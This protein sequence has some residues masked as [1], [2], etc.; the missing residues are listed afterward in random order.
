MNEPQEQQQR[1]GRVAPIMTRLSS[2]ASVGAWWQ[3]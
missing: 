1:A 3:D 2:V